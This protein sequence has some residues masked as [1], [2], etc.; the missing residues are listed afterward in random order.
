MNRNQTI[1][2]NSPNQ[3]LDSFGQFH[4]HTPS[5]NLSGSR[6]TIALLFGGCST[7]YHV[8]LQS[9]YSVFLQIDTSRYSVYLIGLHPQTGQWYWYRGNPERILHDEWCVEEFCVPVFPTTDRFIHGVQ[10]VEDHSVHSISFDAALPILHG[11]NGEDGTVQ[12]LLELTG[13]PIIGCDLLSS[14]LCMNKDL[15]HRLVA[16]EGIATP[17]SILIQP[18]FDKE[19]LMHDIQTLG[20]PIFVKPVRSGS[21]FGITKVLAEQELLPAIERAFV[22]DSHVLLEEMIPGFEVGCAILG[23]NPLTIGAVDEIELSQGFFD[24]T[25]KYTLETAKIHVPARISDKKTKEIQET[26]KQIYTILGCKGF[27]RVDLFLTPEEKI[28]FNEV[29]TIPGFTPHSRY[30]NMLKATGWSFAEVIRQLLKM[31]ECI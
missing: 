9:A 23:T 21:S 10:Y 15:A 13:I 1:E 16:A 22:H 28:V 18:A 31:G 14:A 11:K 20:Y 12:G 30:P 25:E 7:E 17:K 2:E 6:T 3:F 29:N 5:Q 4:S 19:Q 24:Y 27:A 8:S 26:A